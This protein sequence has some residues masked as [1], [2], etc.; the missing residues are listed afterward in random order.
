MAS[1]NSRRGRRVTR[2]AGPPEPPV[3]PAPRARANPTRTEPIVFDS[4]TAQLGAPPPAEPRGVRFYGLG[5]IKE[6]GRNMTVLEHQGKLLIIDC[7]VLFPADQQPGVDLILPDFRPIE[8][9]LDDVVACVVTHG[10]E[11]H[12]GAIPFLLK[13][14]EDIPIVSAR[15][16]LALLSAKLREHRVKGRFNEVAE[17]DR[18]T[19]GPFDLEFFAVNHSIPDALAVGIRTSAGTF[20]HTGDIKLDQVPL[21]GRLTDLA[22]FSRLGDEGVDMLMIDSTNSERP[23]VLTP[24]REVGIAL[25]VVISRAPKRVIVASFASNVHRIQYVIDAAHKNGRKVVFVGRSMVRNMQIAS[26]LGY[27]DLPEGIE[28]DLDEAAR[29][30]ENQVAIVCTG[31]QGEPLAAL[32]RISRGEHR[33][34]TIRADDTVILAASLIPGNET[35]VHAVING[36]AHR[37]AK[38]VT[39]A[40]AKIHVSGHA[41]AGELLFIYNA[42]RP[43]HVMPVHGQWRHLRANG[44]LA[45]STGVPRERVMLVEDGVV[46]DLIDGVASITGRYP[47]GHVYVDGL[48]VGDVGEPTLADRL[49]LSEGGF[50]AVTVA[51]DPRTG[52]VITRPEISARGFSDDPD[53]FEAAVRRVQSEL[54]RLEADGVTDT[55]RIAQAA[56]RAVGKWVAETYRRKPMIVPTVIE[57]ER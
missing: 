32:S 9:R 55:H 45:E 57:V 36:L 14:R 27:L 53:V 25:D 54:R 4:S 10:H 8:D 15:F 43:R 1:E 52:K 35:S 31:S 12:I 18:V 40:E 49:T 26:D 19:Y 50:V 56:R 42:L 6:I 20:L 11:D 3:A 13:M 5:G 22:G 23:G 24:E 33:S 16:T 30:P 44:A 37:G 21:D 34:I 48:A 51:I 41:S 2:T 46:V 38:V 39:N 47:V 17:G 28:V 29:L 7:G